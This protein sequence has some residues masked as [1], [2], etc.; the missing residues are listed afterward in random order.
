MLFV[1]GIK[2]KKGGQNRSCPS[3][4]PGEINHTMAIFS[5]IP[6]H[7][8][9]LAVGN[10]TLSGDNSKISDSDNSLVK[11]SPCVDNV[12]LALLFNQSK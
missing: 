4:A 8:T 12:K 3:V 1:F 7:K 5:L 10:L 9:S 11:F 2:H 6:K